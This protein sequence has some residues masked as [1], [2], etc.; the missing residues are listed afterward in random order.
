LPGV[1]DFKQT[2]DDA[3]EAAMSIGV[4]AVKGTYNGKVQVRDKNEPNSYRLVVEGT[5]RPGFLKG[6]GLIELEDK[7]E[8]T[9]VHYHGQAQVGGM[10]AGVGQRLISASANMVIGQ[11][12][13][14]M[15]RQLGRDA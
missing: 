14:A 15:E 6:D 2:G 13:K 4:G 10:I 12:F 1:K 11:F 3:Y 5:G 9:Q 8:T 7:G